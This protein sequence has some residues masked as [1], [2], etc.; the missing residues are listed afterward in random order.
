MFKLA[1]ISPS[2]AKYTNTKAGDTKFTQSNNIER[3]LVMWSGLSAALLNVAALTPDDFEIE[4]ID[5]NIEDIDFSIKYD[6][7]GITV[8]TQTANRSYQI[9]DIF[10]KNGSLVVL[11]GMHV[12]VLPDEGLEH[13]DCVVIGEAENLWPLFIEDFR[14][15]RIKNVYKT[16]AVVD[17]KE[18][19]VPRYDLIK[20]KN[21]QIVWVQTTRGCPHDCNFCAASRIYGRKYRKKSV[22]QIINEIKIIKEQFDNNCTIGFSDDNLFVNKKYSIKL[23]DSL[24]KLNVNWV[25]QTDI[26]IANNDDVLKRLKKS[27]C[28]NLF[29]GFESLNEKNLENIN[30]NKWKLKQLKDYP[31]NIRKIQSY[32]IGIIG[33][34]IVGMEN[35]DTDVFDRVGRFIIDNNITYGQ[36]TIL[37]PLP[38]TRLWDEME[39]DGRIT[40]YNWDNYTFMKCVIKH[41]NLTKKELEEGAR[42]CYKRINTKE[43]YFKRLQFYKEIYKHLSI[44]Y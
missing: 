16:D 2:G 42:E 41:D 32:G 37:T 36:I 26:S 9:A 29:I 19:G 33:A 21:Y 25:S 13:A 6:I 24:E 17:L 34:F 44:K 22:E 28:T 7:V 11:G 43:V 12:T 23:L 4:I 3:Y 39:K 38:G 10:R 40:D 20:N 30:N 15:N 35:D 5:E 14:N 31:L 27:G 8:M 18:V 1:L